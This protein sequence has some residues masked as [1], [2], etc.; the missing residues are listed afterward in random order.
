MIDPAYLNAYIDRLRVHDWFYERSDDPRTF[1]AGL[2]SAQ[3]LYREAASDPLLL[4]LHGVAAMTLGTERRDTRPGQW[5]CWLSFDEFAEVT[6]RRLVANAT[7]R[8]DPT[9]RLA[10]CVRSL[11]HALAR[12]DPDNGAPSRAMKLLQDLQLLESTLLPAKP[13][14]DP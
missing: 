7:A 1:K 4:E 13:H 9:H 5:Q 10:A 6:R 11:A 2:A 3:K 12:A 8:P 14:V